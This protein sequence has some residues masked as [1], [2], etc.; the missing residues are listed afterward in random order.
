MRLW[1][2]LSAIDVNFD[3]IGGVVKGKRKNQ[4]SAERAREHR[5]MPPSMFAYAC[6]AF[7]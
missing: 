4:K 5:R 1:S 2:N 7:R 6:R 3:R